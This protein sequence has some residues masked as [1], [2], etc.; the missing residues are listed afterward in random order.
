MN[1]REIKIPVHKL[2]GYINE[3]GIS[4]TALSKLS[5]INA[6]HLMKS[7]AG[8]V[9][10]R[11]GEVR[12]LSN[13]N[14]ERLQE[15]LHQISLDLKYIFIYYNPDKEDEKKNGRRYCPDCVVQIKSQ[16]SPYFK[17]RPFMHYALGWK[18]SKIQNV[19]MTNGNITKDDCDRI[20]I[21][22]AEISTRLD[23]FTLTKD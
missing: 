17:I 8:E 2:K 15:A 13:D 14:M 18:R 22:L 6:R 7:L 11:N 10:T 20:N 12:M 16:L 3:V 5:G 23:M 4:M 9:D 1:G 19:M 21:V